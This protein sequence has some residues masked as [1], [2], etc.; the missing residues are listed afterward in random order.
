MKTVFEVY[1]RFGRVISRHVCDHEKELHHRAAEEARKAPA[2]ANL[3]LIGNFDVWWAERLARIDAATTEAD[4][5]DQLEIIRPYAEARWIK[6][7]H[8]KTVD[9]EYP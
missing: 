7:R 4:I 9:G 5:H 1:G 2:D 8:R 3:K 6:D